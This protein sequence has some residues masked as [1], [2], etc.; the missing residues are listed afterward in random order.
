MISPE[1]PTGI[2][3]GRAILHNETDCHGNNTIRIVRAG[4]GNVG[5]VDSEILLAIITSV[6]GASEFDVDGSS[7]FV[8]SEIAEY[9]WDG[10]SAGT[11]FSAVGTGGVLSIALLFFPMGGGK[12]C[13]RVDSFGRIGTVRSRAGHNELLRDS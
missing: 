8:I 4:S 10:S 13:N 7:G 9:T 11:T 2:P 3:I 1:S 6:Y 5:E 12:V